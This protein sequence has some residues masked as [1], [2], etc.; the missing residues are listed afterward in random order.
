M[1]LSL[2]GGEAVTV[3]KC[4]VSV[5][6]DSLSAAVIWLALKKPRAYAD[7]KPPEL[8]SLA[9]M[10]CSSLGSNANLLY[11]QFSLYT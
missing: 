7:K 1:Y 8:A 9:E 11:F 5:S 3:S 4:P 10:G 2:S 6:S